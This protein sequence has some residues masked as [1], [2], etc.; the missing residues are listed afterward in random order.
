MH[1]NSVV[2]N[3]FLIFSYFNSQIIFFLI[4]KKVH[5]FGEMIRKIWS[6]ANFKSTVSPHEF[7][8]AVTIASSRKFR[9]GEQAEAIEFLSWLLNHLHTEIY[10]KQKKTKQSI[11]QQTFQGLVHVTVLKKKKSSLLDKLKL[12]EEKEKK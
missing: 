6:R 9:I 8:Q 7:I 2:V 12:Q 3:N 10:G 11:I 1:S 4:Q 5:R